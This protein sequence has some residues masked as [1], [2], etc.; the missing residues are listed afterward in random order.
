MWYITH[1]LGPNLYNNDNVTIFIIHSGRNY[2][3]AF[4]QVQFWATLLKFNNYFHHRIICQLFVDLVNSF[5]IIKDIIEKKRSRLLLLKAHSDGV[6]WREKLKMCKM[7]CKMSFN[8]VA[9]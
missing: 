6:K 5:F 8:V 7:T 4:I 9:Q 2:Q 3:I 1:C